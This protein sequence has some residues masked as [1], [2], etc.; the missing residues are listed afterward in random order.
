[1][2]C[3]YA[4]CSSLVECDC[5]EGSAKANFDLLS[6]FRCRGYGQQGSLDHQTHLNSAG[7]YTWT[8]AALTYFGQ[9]FL[10]WEICQYLA[11]PALGKTTL[12]IPLST[13]PLSWCL[14]HLC[15]SMQS[16]LGPL[17]LDLCYFT[18]LQQGFTSDS[19]GNKNILEITTQPFDT[20]SLL[21]S[22]LTGSVLVFYW[23]I[24][25]CRQTRLLWDCEW[26]E[27]NA[28]LGV[29]SLSWERCRHLWHHQ[30]P[31]VQWVKVQDWKRWTIPLLK[32]DRWIKSSICVKPWI[33]EKFHN[34]L[35]RNVFHTQI[36]P[37]GFI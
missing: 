12:N 20:F 30:G 33:K 16:L 23:N 24:F 15:T 13:H 6:C 7:W 1:M 19:N 5:S 28:T 29:W 22:W 3:K 18:S 36:C 2:R 4:A 37:T 32:P 11:F 27:L 25:I 35:Q 14:F 9:M 21:G 34:N 26:Y 8:L 10:K 31:I 17:V